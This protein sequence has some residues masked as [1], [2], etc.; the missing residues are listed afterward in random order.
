VL[1]G[2]NRADLARIKGVSTQYADL[3]EGAGVDTLPELTQRND[4]NLHTTM[5]EMT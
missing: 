2:V 1:N 5:V 3:L 4:E